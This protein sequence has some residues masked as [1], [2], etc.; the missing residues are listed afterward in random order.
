MKKNILLLLITLCFTLSAFAKINWVYDMQTAKA[1]AL[2]ENKLIVIDFWATWCGPCKQMES[3]FWNTDKVNEFNNNFIFLKV[4]IDSNR[5]LAM[6]YGVRGIP[7]IVVADI[8][9]NKIWDIVG[10]QGASVITKVLK[11]IPT[12]TTQLNKALLPFLQEKE[13]YGDFVNAGKAYAEIG[14][15]IKNKGLKKSFLSV[16][17]QLLKK[18]KK[19]EFKEEVELRLLLNKAYLGQS[20]N[21]LKK[22]NK[23]AETEKNKELRNF[24]LEYI[25]K[26]LD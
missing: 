19:S 26:E 24:I 17:N 20:K 7:Y 11:N 8:A 3:E 5:R 23:I 4:D 14:K 12:Q 25:K 13:S 9:G 2:S 16:S 22:V 21:L 6:Q 18:A 10:Y 15:D 1:L